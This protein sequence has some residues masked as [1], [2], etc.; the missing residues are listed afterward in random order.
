MW[1]TCTGP[2]VCARAKSLTEMQRLFLSSE[3][4]QLFFQLGLL[5]RQLRLLRVL[6][7]G[8]LRLIGVGIAVRR[9]ICHQQVEMALIFIFV[10]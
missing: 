2:Y 4:R 8:Q 1:T 6:L 3:R 5:P 7:R 10:L 9:L